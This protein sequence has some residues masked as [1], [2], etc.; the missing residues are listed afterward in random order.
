MSPSGDANFSVAIRT[1]SV[2]GSEIVMNVGGGLTH[3]STAQ[4]EWEEALWKA[5]FVKAAVSRDL[6]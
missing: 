1:L 4:G 5:R 2:S 6:S 3:G